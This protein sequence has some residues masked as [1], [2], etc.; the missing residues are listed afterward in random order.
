LGYLSDIIFIALLI[1]V[2]NHFS[3]KSFGV[4]Y[5]VVFK[6]FWTGRHDKLKDLALAAHM[7]DGEISYFTLIEKLH[8]IT[9]MERVDIFKLAR[10]EMGFGFSDDQVEKH[11]TRYVESGHQEI[12]NYVEA[13][14]DKGRDHIINA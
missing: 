10:T 9:D 3:K 1:V 2:L 4:N 6:N 7:K 13:F 11:F 5:W 8:Q 14:L 12:P